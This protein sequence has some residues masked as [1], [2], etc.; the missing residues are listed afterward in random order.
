MT[1]LSL[2][3]PHVPNHQNRFTFLDVARALAALA[4]MIQHSIE[5]SGMQ[6]LQHGAFATTW[7]NL[8]ETGVVMFF[9][10]SGFIIPASIRGTPT[11]GKFWIRRILRIYPL[12][13]VMFFVTLAISVLLVGEPMPNMPVTIISH[14]FIVQGWIGLRNYVGGSWT[15]LIE[16]VWYASFSIAAFSKY[17][18]GEK[19]VQTFLVCFACVILGA[20]IFYGN[21]PFGRFCMY[22]LCFMGYTYFLRYEEQITKR[23]FNTLLSAF[24]TLIF[25]S[26][27][28]GFYLNPSDAPTAPAFWC[29]L[30]SWGISL[31]IFPLL[32][33]R[34]DSKF[35]N[36]A[37]L[38]YLGEISYSVYL[39]HSPIITVLKQAGLSGPLFVLV[40]AMLT[41][42][43]GT[44]TFKYIERPG[45]ALA[46]RWTAKPKAPDVVAVPVN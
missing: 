36:S 6:S 34:R 42:L 22:A 19:I 33:V 13:W 46:R 17:G 12:Y 15:L 25:A 39:L 9:L 31:V 14:I 4:V 45:I 41:I 29:V 21:F 40:T 35:A 30:I 10:V 1:E 32:F 7:L 11:F 8:G 28:V 43:L 3:L 24:L 2:K 5:G 27:Y 44:F 37:I 16:I 26:I 20:S 18:A 23:R 38:A